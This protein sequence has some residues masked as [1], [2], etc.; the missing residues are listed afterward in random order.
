[1]NDDQ[2]RKALAEGIAKANANKALW[3]AKVPGGY[4]GRHIRTVKSRQSALRMVTDDL[5][6]WAQSTL[7]E[8]DSIELVQVRKAS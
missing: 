5:N 4:V 2:I 7:V 3:I 8:R 6:M 1:M